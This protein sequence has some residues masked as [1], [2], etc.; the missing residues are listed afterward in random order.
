MDIVNV[1]ITVTITSLVSGSIS[2]IFSALGTIKVLK[3]HL[4]Y[5]K[6]ELERHE[7]KLAKHSERL[8]LVEMSHG[9]IER[10]GATNTGT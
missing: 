5:M 1:I 10:K 8:R 2:G 4:S 3:V 9:K 6:E 7:T